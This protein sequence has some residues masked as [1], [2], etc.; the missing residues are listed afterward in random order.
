MPGFKLRK[1]AEITVCSLSAKDKVFETTGIFRGTTMLS[2]FSAFIMEM[3]GEKKGKKNVRLVPEHMIL[4]I[5][6][7]KNGEVEDEE[8]K[9]KEKHSSQYA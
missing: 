3:P 5:D 9:D 2:Q 1:N 6:I 8:K 7:H 4:T